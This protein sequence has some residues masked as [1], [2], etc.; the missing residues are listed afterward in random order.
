MERVQTSPCTAR[1]ELGPQW[2][3][4]GASLSRRYVLGLGDQSPR[5]RVLG[6]HRA[7]H[8]G[9]AGLAALGL[10]SR[11]REHTHPVL[12]RWLYCSRILWTRPPTC[13]AGTWKANTRKCHRYFKRKD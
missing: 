4:V 6:R 9:K 7:E 2:P 12:S 11:F 8:V 3:G 5:A 13:Q 10:P 1:A